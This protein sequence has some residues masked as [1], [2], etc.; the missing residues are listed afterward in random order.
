MRQAQGYGAADQRGGRRAAPTIFTEAGIDLL[1]P[2]ATD[3]QAKPFPLLGSYAVCDHASLSDQALDVACRKPRRQWLGVR[4]RQLVIAPK[5]D[6][7]IGAWKS[8]KVPRSEFAIGK[9]AYSLGSAYQWCIISFQCL[10]IDCRVL[11]LVNFS[12]QRYEAILGVLASEGVRVLC[13]YEYHATEPGWHCHAACD[14]VSKIPSRYMRGP[15]VRRIPGARKTHVSL[16][17]DVR[18]QASAQRFAISCYRIE[19]KGPLI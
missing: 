1:P 6:I 8:G 11:V 19:S 13:S 16:N 3:H 10:D 7:K 18:D 5:S 4:L 14:D 2:L 9:S 15:W 17:F 12:K